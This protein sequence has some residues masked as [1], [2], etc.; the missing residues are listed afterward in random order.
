M[1]LVAGEALTRF[2]VS[3][4]HNERF[5]EFFTGEAVDEPM[6]YRFA[7]GK[8][9]AVQLIVK[10]GDLYRTVSLDYHGGLR[11]PTLERIP[12]KTDYLTDIFSPRK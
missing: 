3:L 6:D 4:P 12:G 8:G 9:P 2:T 7:N 5:A 10:S 11:Y 1:R